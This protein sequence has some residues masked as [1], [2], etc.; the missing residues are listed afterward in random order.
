MEQI[1]FLVTEDKQ[2]NRELL[3]I[4][5]SGI[6]VRETDAER[7]PEL[8]ATEINVVKF[9]REQHED[10]ITCGCVT[11]YAASGFGTYDR[12]LLEK[13]GLNRRFDF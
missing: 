7:N 13:Y 11:G 10:C 5:Y 8:N 1:I 6:F 4:T 9:M 12:E 2:R 3:R